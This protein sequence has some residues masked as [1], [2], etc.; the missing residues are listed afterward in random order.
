MIAILVY[1]LG[2]AIIP[3]ILLTLFEIRGYY[4]IH[5]PIAMVAVWSAA[6]LIGVRYD[7]GGIHSQRRSRGNGKSYDI[8]DN[9]SF[10]RRVR[11]TTR[12]V[13]DIKAY[14]RG[15]AGGGYR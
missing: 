11:G 9:Q 4:Y 2:I 8:Y 14:Y 15:M 6:I 12:G 3:M 5:E 1:L 7:K 10:R 13:K